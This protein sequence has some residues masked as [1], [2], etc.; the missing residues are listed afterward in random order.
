MGSHSGGR[1]EGNAWRLWALGPILLLA[2]V[3][4]AFVTSGSSLLELVG[5]SPPPADVFD[6]R[7]VE[8]R[9]GEIKIRVTNPQTDAITI[10]SV[11]VDDAIVP[12]LIDGSQEVKRLRSSTIVVPYDW[13]P[14]EP[15]SVG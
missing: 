13:V 7:R 4:G 5:R 15:L 11:T 8:F 9:T 3:V 2:A 12:F 14:D 10:A 1:P 6:I